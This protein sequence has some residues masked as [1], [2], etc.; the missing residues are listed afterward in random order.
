MSRRTPRILL[1]MLATLGLAA[2]V[3]YATI[4]LYPRV[5][6]SVACGKAV[7]R[8]GRNALIHGRP[9]TAQS[10]DV[11]FASPDLIYSVVAYDLSDGPLRITAPVPG[12][13]MSV[14]AYADNTDNFFV[15]N[16]LQVEQRRFDVILVGPDSPDPGVE[17]ARLV[18][19]PSATGGI[20]VRYFL[21]S[22]DQLEHIESVR[23]RMTCTL[24]DQP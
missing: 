21:R 17:G 3:H 4:V 7:D 19:S 12:S 13:Y 9:L 5:Y 18:R 10:R 14:S 20:L 24:L 11:A 22:D 23:R 2:A 8:G 6:M 15:M 1:W 16:D